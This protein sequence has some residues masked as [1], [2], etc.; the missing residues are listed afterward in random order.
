MGTHESGGSTKV[1]LTAILVNLFVTIAKGVG[2]ILSMSPSMLAEAIHSF[3]DTVNQCLVYVGIRVSKKGP[4]RDFP[5]GYGQARYLWN[6][7]SATG[8]F[9]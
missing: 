5:V 6:L 7:I 4:T 9:L 2:W 1:V 8:I 3:A